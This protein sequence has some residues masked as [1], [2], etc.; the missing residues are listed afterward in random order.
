MTTRLISYQYLQIPNNC[1]SRCTFKNTFVT[2][3]ENTVIQIMSINTCVSKV[4]KSVSI[5]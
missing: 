4:G 1:E 3:I 5:Q 2:I